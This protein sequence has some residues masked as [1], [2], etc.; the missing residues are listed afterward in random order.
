VETVI[1]DTIPEPGGWSIVPP[2]DKLMLRLRQSAVYTVSTRR[3]WPLQVL[4]QIITKS[5]LMI[6]L[7]SYS[8]SITP[9][10]ST[11]S[12]DDL[13]SLILSKYI[14]VFAILA[15]MEQDDKIRDFIDE[16][17]HDADLPLRFDRQGHDVVRNGAPDRPLKCFS[18]LKNFERDMFLDYQWRMLAPYFKLSSTTPIKHMDLAHETILPF[19]EETRA[20]EGGF[21]NVSKVKIH[22]HCFSW[23]D[24]K[25]QVQL[26]ICRRRRMKAHMPV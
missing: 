24:E 13:A 7:S 10:S 20:G 16:E 3:F 14:R 15:I 18:I 9:G 12:I 1:V 19:I 23:T 25:T 2:K 11:N 26:Y 21:A 6:T 22:H 4:Q 5:A 8:M 17:V